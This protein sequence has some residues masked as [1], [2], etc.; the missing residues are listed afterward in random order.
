MQRT[1]NPAANNQVQKAPRRRLEHL[2]DLQE[3]VDKFD[4]V[5]RCLSR[6]YFDKKIPE[7]KYRLLRMMMSH[8]EYF[9][10][11]R[12][13]L[14]ERMS[15]ASLAKY[16]PQLISE[17]YLE[18]ESI[19]STRGGYEN[20]YHVRSLYDW[21][22]HRQ[23]VDG[24]PIDGRLVNDHKDTNP[25]SSST[26]SNSQS[27]SKTEN[28][29][30]NDDVDLI[31]TAIT[32]MSEPKKKSTSSLGKGVPSPIKQSVL[33][34]QS[35]EFLYSKRRNGSY[36]WDVANTA[37][38]AFIRSH[39]INAAELLRNWATSSRGYHGLLKVRSDMFEY[40]WGEFRNREEL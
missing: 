6:A 26:D 2:A 23:S 22:L 36:D 24:S 30:H 20:T 10:V 11:K 29:C 3:G 27:E 32:P 31:R 14:E 21:P 19:A 8:G 15:K 5:P 7:P 37:A 4:M 13:Y 17:G 34:A 18:C 38:E 35:M 9:R 39:D 28:P 12:T 40:L 33:Y 25:S 16:L 1:S